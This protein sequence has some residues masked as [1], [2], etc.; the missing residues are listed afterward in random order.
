MR[1]S[2]LAEREALA[3]F[4]C[5]H[6]RGQAGEA[7]H[8]VEHD[9]GLG[10]RGKLGEHTGIVAAQ[11]GELRP[12][13]ELARLL[14]D[15]LAVAPRGEREH[16]VVVAV[17]PDDVE[18]LRADGTRGAEEDD[19]PPRRHQ[20]MPRDNQVVDR[21]Q[22]EQHGVEPVE[23]PPVAGEQRAEI[24]QAEVALEHRLA[25]IAEWGEDG[26]DEAEQQSVGEAVPGMQA[27][28]L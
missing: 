8:R 1:L 10:V 22:A 3:V 21:G 18:R 9:V 19:P 11:A 23:H 4:E 26:N 6:R 13:V 12:H 16:F 20:M 7:D 25:E 24:L 14:G 2:L 27:E 17:V 28:D 5:R 15:Q